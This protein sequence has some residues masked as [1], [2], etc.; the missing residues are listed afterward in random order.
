MMDTNDIRDMNKCEVCARLL[1]RPIFL[2]ACGHSPCCQTCAVA[3]KIK[4]CGRC[5]VAVKTPPARLKVNM[6]LSALL[7]C[8]WPDDYKDDRPSDDVL[9]HEIQRKAT[10]EKLDT[11]IARAGKPGV[12]HA[13]LHESYRSAALRI[14][15]TEYGESSLG[16]HVL[17]WCECGL[18]ELP[19][20]SKKSGRHFFGCPAWTPMACKRKRVCDDEADVAIGV[21]GAH[22]VPEDVKYCGSFAHTSK[23]QREVMKLA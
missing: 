7:R 5:G 6:G 19:K 20:F 18:I 22:L 12:Y 15:D 9:L 3:T 17:R 14:I 4:K 8:M 1:C 21:D 16:T 10:V 13:M 23:K 11:A 2:P